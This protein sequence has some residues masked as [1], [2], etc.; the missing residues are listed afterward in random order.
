MLKL[1]LLVEAS[2]FLI[3]LG[4]NPWCNRCISGRN[5]QTK[6]RDDSL[7]PLE[8]KDPSPSTHIKIGS[9][10]TPSNGVELSTHN[11]L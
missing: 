4:I 11:K 2:D 3:F 1:F 8:M 7:I 10:L 6:I 5:R 9:P